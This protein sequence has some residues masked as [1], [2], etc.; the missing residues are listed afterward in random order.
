MLLWLALLFPSWDLNELDHYCTHP[1]KVDESWV[2]ATY[3]DL[4]G[5]ATPY[6][7]RWFKGATDFAVFEGYGYNLAG[8]I[9][10]AEDKEELLKPLFNQANKKYSFIKEPDLRYYE[11]KKHKRHLPQ[12]V[13]FL[14][15]QNNDALVLV[16]CDTRFN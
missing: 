13:I 4:E 2:G 7:D 8:V 1:P 16:T 6:P 14:T 15:D 12:R 11:L 3:Y 10:R 9:V 5:V